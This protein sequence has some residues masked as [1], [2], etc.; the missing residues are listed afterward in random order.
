MCVYTNVRSIPQLRFLKGLFLLLSLQ[1][2][3][4]GHREKKQNTQTPSEVNK[5]RWERSEKGSVLNNRIEMWNSAQKNPT[6]FL[7]CYKSKSARGW[8]IVWSL[9]IS[10]NLRLGISLSQ[11][12]VLFFPSFK[13]VIYKKVTETSINHRPTLSNSKFDS[14]LLE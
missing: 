11:K 3:L 5:H 8:L 1:W 4:N 9:Q 10:F 7:I 13:A 12:R 14:A 6:G 2:C